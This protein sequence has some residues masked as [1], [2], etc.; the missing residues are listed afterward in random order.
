VGLLIDTSALVAV[1]R[2]QG[3]P[4]ESF[5]D[6]TVALPAIVLAELLV[7]VRL[8][9]TPARAAQRQ[10]KVD[11]LTERVQVVAFDRFIA[12][13]WAGLFALMRR[14]GTLIPSNDLCVAAT[15]LHLDFGVLV[16]PA[17]EAHFRCVPGL[18]VEVL[19][20]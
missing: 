15:A 9:D 14:E 18:R 1:E 3:Q 17:D 19:S 13:Q 20:D 10:R 4:P 11:A 6:E 7:G 5:T 16:G 2:G 8:A 12:D